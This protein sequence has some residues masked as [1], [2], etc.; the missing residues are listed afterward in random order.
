MYF[1]KPQSWIRWAGPMLLALG[2]CTASLKAQSSDANQ[3]RSYLFTIKKANTPTSYLFGTIHLP[4]ARVARVGQ[5]VQNAFNASDAV[6]TEIPMDPAV[7]ATAATAM[8]LPPEDSLEN[9]LPS[10]TMK[11]FDEELKQIN[12]A[13][14]P[15]P[16]LQF[17]VWAAAATLML[18]ETQ[19]NNPGIKAMDM[20]LYTIAEDRG[21]RVGALETPEEQL[22]VFEAFSR[23]EQI[24]LF[25]SLLETMKE[26]RESGTNYTDVLVD[27]YRTGD[28][29]VLQELMVTYADENTKLQQKFERLLLDNRNFLMAD[30]ISDEISKYPDESIFFAVGAAHLYGT[31]GVINLLKRAGFSVERA[32]E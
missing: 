7:M 17:K 1:L 12:P 4:D 29:D 26:L 3:G 13:L 24:E 11:R 27:A 15:T 31:D 8:M 10:R 9:I 30:R 16:F 14:D 6:Y 23:Q 32:Y 28:L 25:D 21:K 20:A 18:L 2:L 5:D 22:A 19:L